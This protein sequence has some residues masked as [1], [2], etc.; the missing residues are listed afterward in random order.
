MCACNLGA[1]V[2]TVPPP[3]ATEVSASNAS[4]LSNAAENGFGTTQVDNGVTLTLYNQPQHPLN[5]NFFTGS[6]VQ[7]HPPLVTG[8]H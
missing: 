8:V 6:Q 2:T 4:R 7:V 5:T 1:E 3:L